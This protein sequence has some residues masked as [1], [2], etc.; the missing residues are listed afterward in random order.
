MR[1]LIFLFVSA[2]FA[3]VASGCEK[4]FD[5]GAHKAKLN[6]NFNTVEWQVGDF[7]GDGVED[8]VLVVSHYKEDIEMV[9][10]EVIYPWPWSTEPESSEILTSLV[11][12]HGNDAA[13]PKNVLMVEASGSLATPSFQLSVL[14]IDDQHYDDTV[15]NFSTKPEGDVIV[16]PTEAGIDTYM[17]RDGSGYVYFAPEELP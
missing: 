7:D 5:S 14:G 1:Y 8:K 17:Y 4:G 3:G 6:N 9:D 11:V 12:I 13:S 15:A 10:L 2:M 16:L